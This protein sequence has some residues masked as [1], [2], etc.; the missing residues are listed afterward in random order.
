[1]LLQ[2]EYVYY[3]PL[4]C[5]LIVVFL[6]VNTWVLMSCQLFCANFVELY[7]QAQT[8][9]AWGRCLPPKSSSSVPQWSPES[10]PYKRGD[11]VVCKGVFYVANADHTTVE[12]GR[13]V[14]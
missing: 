7:L 5:A 4:R 12:P 14:P 11:V 13:V 9:G 10:S 3:D 1:M 8:M 6:A 2:H